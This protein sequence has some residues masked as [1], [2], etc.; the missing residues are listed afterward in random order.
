MVFRHFPCEVLYQYTGMCVAEGVGS[1]S[2]HQLL[3]ANND[4]TEN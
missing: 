1:K 4:I 3:K 2:Q